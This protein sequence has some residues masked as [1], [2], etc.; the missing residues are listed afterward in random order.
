[1]KNLLNFVLF[2]I[3]SNTFYAQVVKACIPQ[4]TKNTNYVVDFTAQHVNEKQNFNIL[5]DA[6]ETT[7][8]TI[9]IPTNWVQLKG[10]GRVYRDSLRM[11]KE[12]FTPN[13][14]LKD[15][16]GHIEFEYSLLKPEEL[17]FWYRT[18]ESNYFEVNLK[19]EFTPRPR[20]G[21]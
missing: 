10:Y 11:E 12:T 7:K 16:M 20:G 14:H 21:C 13:Y 4:V 9:K 17:K 3:I 8:L 5:V 18:G 15:K 19:V 6:N 1:M 2:L